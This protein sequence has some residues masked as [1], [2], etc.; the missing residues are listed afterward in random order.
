M[1]NYYCAYCD[2]ELTGSFG[3]N[4]YCDN[5]DISFETDWDYIDAGDGN[6]SAWLTGVEY[7][8]KVEASDG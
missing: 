4:V 7:K 6:M 5:C 8:G 2:K 1:L 3:D